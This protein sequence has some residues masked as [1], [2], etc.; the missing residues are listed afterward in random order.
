[1]LIV[2]S[3]AQLHAGY[4][5]DHRDVEVIQYLDWQVVMEHIEGYPALD[6]LREARIYEIP[7]TS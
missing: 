5:V 2:M 6:A 1:M 7:A 3:F 4:G